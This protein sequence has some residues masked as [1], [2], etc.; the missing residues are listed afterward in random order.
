MSL[1]KEDVL[2]KKWELQ[3]DILKLLREFTEDTS[4]TVT[5]IELEFVSFV[6]NVGNPT[7]EIAYV[8]AKVEL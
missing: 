8:E 2:E 3:E 6:S 4:F 1:T 7:S 5:S